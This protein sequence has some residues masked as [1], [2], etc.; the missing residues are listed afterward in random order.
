LTERVHSLRP[1]PRF[2]DI[3]RMVVRSAFAELRYSPLRLAGA[4]LGMCLTYLAPPLLAIFAEGWAR[5]LGLAAWAMLALSFQP[6]LRLYGRSPAWGFALPLIALI[7]TG[8]TVDSAIQH[9]RGKGG[10]WKGR[11]Q[12]HSSPRRGEV[13]FGASR[14]GEGDGSHRRRRTGARDGAQGHGR[15]IT[16]TEA[17]SGKG[18]GDEN[19]PVASRLIRAENRAPI[20]AFY[21]FVRAADDVADHPGLSADEKLRMLDALESALLGRG[22]ADPEAEPLRR[23]LAERGL[24]PRHAQDLLNAFRM[25]ARKNRY[26]DWGELIGYCALSAMPVGRF[27]LD[28]HG[29]APERVWAASDAICAALQVNNHLQDCGADYRSLDRVYLPL[30]VLAKH[31]AR[32]E[33]L[34]ADRASPALRAAIADLAVRTATLLREGSALPDLIA[35]T[36]LS[37][38]IAAIYRLAGSI[39]AGLQ[40]RDPLSEKVHIGKAGFAIL[41]LSAAAGALFRRPFLGRGG[42]PRAMRAGTR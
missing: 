38:E 12:A 27:V 24:S 22:P 16:A 20:L 15:M 21:R 1:Y 2:D 41:A 31:G 25:D 4:V 23:A 42:S 14:A 13:E 34:G 37:L 18:H 35:D 32:V 3:R 28:V 8:F 36:R 6:M 5:G 33:D 19:F 29:E 26:A 30:D 39:A 10:A 7:Y 9:W 11:F 40:R 17:K